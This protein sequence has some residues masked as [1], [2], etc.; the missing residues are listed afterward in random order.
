M[1]GRIWVGRV[2][3]TAIGSTDDGAPIMLHDDGIEVM[4][5][6]SHGFSTIKF[7]DEGDE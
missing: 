1:K 5:E 2:G 4:D 6:L 3:G 7:D